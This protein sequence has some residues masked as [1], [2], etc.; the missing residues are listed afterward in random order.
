MPGPGT[1][2]NSCAHGDSYANGPGK[3]DWCDLLGQALNL[4][5]WDL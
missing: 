3:L 1:R 5:R 2:G 4:S